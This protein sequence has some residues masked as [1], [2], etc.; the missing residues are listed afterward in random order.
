MA[1]L[2]PNPDRDFCAGYGRRDPEIEQALAG[3]PLPWDD[4]LDDPSIRDR[5]GKL[6]VDALRR[7]HKPD[8]G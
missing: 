7:N 6:I 5:V 4:I 3:P 8:A 1:R 2:S